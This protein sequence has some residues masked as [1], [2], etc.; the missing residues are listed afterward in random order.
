MII[1]KIK[2]N[3]NKKV[4]FAF[5]PFVLIILVY[6]IFIKINYEWNVN[7][8]SEKYAEK[9]DENKSKIINAFIANKGDFDAVIEKFYL[10]DVDVDISFFNDTIVYKVNGKE[11][12]LRDEDYALFSKLYSILNCE[13]IRCSSESK[14]IEILIPYDERC[15]DIILYS[16]NLEGVMKG[17]SPDWEFSPDWYFYSIRYAGE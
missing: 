17:L 13:S 16:P 15:D 11:E 4:L 12:K 14:D 5:I 1:I 3:K 8:I 10:K 9:Y 2:N 7:S 6:I